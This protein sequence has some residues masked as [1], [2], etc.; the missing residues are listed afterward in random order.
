MATTKTLYWAH[1]G[2]ASKADRLSQMTDRWPRSRSRSLLLTVLNIY[3]TSF[4]TL[5]ICDA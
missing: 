5:L 4:N 3:L 1:G 2:D